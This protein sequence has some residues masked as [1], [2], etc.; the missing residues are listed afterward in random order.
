MSKRAYVIK[1]NDRYVDN[2]Q[3]IT[4]EE[5][6][7]LLSRMDSISFVIKE[8]DNYYEAVFVDAIKR[9]KYFR[10]KSL[11]PISIDPKFSHGESE[12]HKRTC[13]A[14]Y[15][16]I[17]S[18]DLFISLSEEYHCPFVHICTINSNCNI[19]ISP[20]IK[21]ISLSSMFDT[22]EIETKS[23]DYNR[24]PDIHLLSS[25]FK[26]EL[27]IELVDTH[28]C[29]G[30]KILEGIPI[31]EIPIKTERQAEAVLRLKTIEENK[32]NKFYNIQALPIN[33]VGSFCEHYNDELRY[34]RQKEITLNTVLCF[35]KYSGKTIKQVI[36][37]D[38]E[39]V[40]WMIK[41]IDKDKG[42]FYGQFTREQLISII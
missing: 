4:P 3:P 21:K 17:V 42:S 27:W 29:G 19:C 8:G 7:G 6:R 16:K 5:A 34:H 33:F 12:L 36:K 30:D 23:A 31:I 22:V 2:Y 35:G 39:Y 11:S 24:I 37:E 9:N 25:R 20:L 28:S 41:T 13:K 32:Y 38:I 10:K 26:H 15:D 18:S 14:L 40:K 1:Q